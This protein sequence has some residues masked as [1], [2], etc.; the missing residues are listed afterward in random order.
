MALQDAIQKTVNVTHSECNGGA[1][2]EC[3]GGAGV[4]QTLCHASMAEEC[5]YTD[6]Q[7]QLNVPVLVLVK[8]ACQRNE[9]VFSSMN[10][11]LT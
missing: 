9:P 10:V 7:Q 5:S 3:N 6:C 8:A 11:Q 1:G 4:L 2:V